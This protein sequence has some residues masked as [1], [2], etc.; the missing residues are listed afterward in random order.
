MQQRLASLVFLA[1]AAAAVVVLA[2]WYRAGS[3]VH[4][5]SAPTSMAQPQEVSAVAVPA[6]N[7][8]NLASATLPAQS[9]EQWITDTQSAD[10]SKRAAAIAALAR[11]PKDQVLPVLRRLLTDAEPL[12]DRPMALQSLRDLA[13]NQ[14]DADGA[15]REAVRNAIYH[16]DDQTKTDD[17]QEVLDII[18]ESERR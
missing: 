9:V 12:V 16:G 3:P 10:A 7:D 15:I 1:V 18:E 4:A 13:L 17:V 14:G 11:A 8:V 2:V 5:A 6:V